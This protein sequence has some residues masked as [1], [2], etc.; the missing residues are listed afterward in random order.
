MGFGDRGD[1]IVERGNAEV[2]VGGAH[3]VLQV[4]G[5]ALGALGDPQPRQLAWIDWRKVATGSWLEHQGQA[6]GDV[7]ALDGLLELPQQAGRWDPVSLR[8]A[9]MASP[10]ARSSEWGRPLTAGENEP[11]GVLLGRDD[12]ER[13]AV[14]LAGGL[15]AVEEP[16]EPRDRDLRVARVA[17]VDPPAGHG[18][19]AYGSW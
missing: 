3:L 9:L 19:P 6:R 1:E 8:S 12:D 2:L 15:G 4:G 14:D 10:C 16:P 13:A 18:C 11:A 7:R 17:V 5:P